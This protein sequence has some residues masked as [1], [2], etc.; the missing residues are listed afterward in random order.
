MDDEQVRDRKDFL[1]ITDADERRIA[2]L[3]P[4]LHSIAPQL[5]DSFY[6]HLMSR[7]STASFLRDAQLVQRL[8][9]LQLQYFE[10]L[11]SGRYDLEYVQDR[12]RVGATHQNIGLEPRWYLGAWSTWIQQ[13]FPAFAEPLGSEIP[14]QLM[15]LLKVVLLDIGLTLEAWF[16]ASAQS[17]QHRNAELEEALH[18]YF[19]TEMKARQYA[20]LA[21]HEIRSSL[22]AIGNVLEEVVEDFSDEIPPEA[23]AALQKAN[24]RCLQVM[25][26]VE[27]ILADPEHP[28]QPRWTDTADLFRDIRQ[29]LP[30][31]AESRDIT[32]Q[33]PPESITVWADPIGLREV[34]ANLVANAAHH[35]DK[36]HG[37]IRIEH[38][39]TPA[40]H[41]FTVADNGPG[42][43]ADQQPRIF[44]PFYRTGSGQHS[45]KGLGL[46]FVRTIIEQH[47]G[48]VWV[49]SVE[50]NGSRFSF[51]LPVKPIGTPEARS[52]VA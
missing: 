41:I 46:Y 18:M 48:Q 12:I 45:G 50:G 47:G 22:N 26:V 1:D 33:T 35:L 51:C 9:R 10:Q 27:K 32:L 7:G 15:S 21:G 25:Q 5:I 17:L 40:R 4:Y 49:D 3:R 28:S 37:V 13:C 39:A 16:Q 14:P 24:A 36:A 11:V 19:H 34:F 8:K 42:I 52:H 38:R 29:R 43:P 30:L 2:E 31:Y 23:R 6:A 20:R 44:R